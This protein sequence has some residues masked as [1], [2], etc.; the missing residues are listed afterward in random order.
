MG[1]KGWREKE[2]GG[3]EEKT[4]FGSFMAFRGNRIFCFGFRALGGLLKNP[5]VQ[6]GVKNGR[7][8][9]PIFHFGF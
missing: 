6:F 2:G 3:G 7:P 9:E 5:K 1:R 4:R 8:A